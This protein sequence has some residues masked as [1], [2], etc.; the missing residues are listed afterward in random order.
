MSTYHSIQEMSLLAA[1]TNKLC[2]RLSYTVVYVPTVISLNPSTMERRIYLHE[3]V[4]FLTRMM[5][6]SMFFS[7]DIAH[8]S[9]KILELNLWWHGRESLNYF[10]L[11]NRFILAENYFCVRFLPIFTS[12]LT[13]EEYQLTRIDYRTATPVWLK[14]SFHGYFVFN[15]MKSISFE[16]DG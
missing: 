13:L 8:N 12:K 14:W 15:H 5:W 2:H 9:W 4:T 3:C 1:L 11:W 16:Q 6:R 10:C 7:S